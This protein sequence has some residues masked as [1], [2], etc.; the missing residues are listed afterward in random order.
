MRLAGKSSTRAAGGRYGEDTAGVSGSSVGS[1][2]EDGE[3]PKFAITSLIGTAC[4]MPSTQSKSLART[5][6]R[7][8]PSRISL[9][10]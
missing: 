10:L 1:G 8:M 5:L 3:E 2:S 9:S 6:L 4:A 7:S